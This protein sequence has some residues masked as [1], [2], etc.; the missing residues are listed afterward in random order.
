[1]TS[2][3]N[4]LSQI[5]AGMA[6]IE[7]NNY[8][9]RDVRAANILVGKNQI[10]KVADFGLARLIIDDQYNAQQ[11]D[12]TIESHAIQAFV[13]FRTVLLSKQPNDHM[14]PEKVFGA[15]RHIV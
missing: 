3:I 15:T 6:F 5:A 8:I 2:K 9:H 12:V 7:R 10:C 13:T 14:R 4:A 11:G 1:M